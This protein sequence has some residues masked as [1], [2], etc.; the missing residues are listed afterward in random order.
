[1]DLRVWREKPE[2][3]WAGKK[4]AVALVSGPGGESVKEA[5]RGVDGRLRCSAAEEVGRADQGRVEKQA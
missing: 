3:V 5:G 1:M 4:P 2:V